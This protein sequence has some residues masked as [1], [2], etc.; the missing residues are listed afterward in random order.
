M[1]LNEPLFFEEDL[2]F[3]SGLYV[4]LVPRSSWGQNLRAVMGKDEWRQL[5]SAVALRCNKRC[6]ACG[7][8]KARIECH[9]RWDYDLVSGIQSLRRL[10][11]LCSSCHRAT[12]FGFAQSIGRGGQALAQLQKIN[13]WRIEEAVNHVRKAFETWE[14]R[15]RVSWI[16]DFPLTLCPKLQ[17]RVLD[18]PDPRSP[19]IRVCRLVNDVCVGCQRSSGEISAWGKMTED[20][21]KSLTLRILAQRPYNEA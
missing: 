10:V 9:E 5:S 4:D 20:Q 14:D 6:Q 13:Q 1:Q 17:K 2:D 16:V 18:L 19:C 11:G 12:H 3:G 7:V 15:S 8:E 21:Q